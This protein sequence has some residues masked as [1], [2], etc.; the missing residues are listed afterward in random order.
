[1]TQTTIPHNPPPFSLNP[2]FARG[3]ADAYDDSQRHHPATLQDFAHHALDFITP[4][5][6]RAQHLY[7]AGYARAALENLQHHLAEEEAKATQIEQ[8]QT[9][10]ARKQGRETSTLHTRRRTR[11]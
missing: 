11:R 5:S 4:T 6:S 7:A 2:D 1:M 8:A 9:W 3:R 10:L